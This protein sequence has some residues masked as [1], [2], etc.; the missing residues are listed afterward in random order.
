MHDLVHFS[1]SWRSRCAALWVICSWD[2]LF[3]FRKG[4]IV[5]GSLLD[6]PAERKVA[7]SCCF[8]YCYYYFFPFQKKHTLMNSWRC[9]GTVKSKVFALV[10]CLQEHCKWLL[11]SSSLMVVF[12]HEVRVFPCTV[13]DI[14]SLWVNVH[15]F[16]CPYNTQLCKD[17]RQRIQPVQGARR[18]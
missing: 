6:L 7:L 14:A 1:R 13:I 8:Y 17:G 3:G 2:Q 18:R 16:I 11:S 5:L 15:K 12:L 4:L 9:D 10:S